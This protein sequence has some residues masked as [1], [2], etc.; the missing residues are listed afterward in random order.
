LAAFVSRL[1][2]TSERPIALMTDDAESLLRLRAFLSVPTR[3]ALDYFH[4]SMKLGHIDQCI[5]AIRPTVLSPGG[6]V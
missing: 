6:S 2:I 3:F 1:H 4:V 5:G